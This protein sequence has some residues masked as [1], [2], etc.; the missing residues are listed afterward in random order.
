MKHFISFFLAPV[1]ALLVLVLV[2]AGGSVEAESYQTTCGGGVPG[3]VHSNGGG[4]VP[5]F[6]SAD[7]PESPVAD[8]VYVGPSSI[9]CDGILSGKVRIINS[10]VRGGTISGNVV[11][12]NSVIGGPQY[13]GGYTLSISGNARIVGSYVESGTVTGTAVI[14]N[15]VKISENAQVY[16]AAKL[17]GKGTQVTGN[18]V[19]FGNAVVRG[20]TWV[21]G[22]GKVNC[23]RWVGV[24]IRD[25]QRGKCGRNGNPVLSKLPIPDVESLSNP[26]E[27]ENTESNW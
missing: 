17:S 2:L 15:G 16:G 26:T 21:F 7:E 22:H 12:R 1:F 3:Q 20:G 9:V 8:S 27:P 4:W 13:Y 6:A 19:V 10:T 24:D 11:I 5:L 14:R 18:A 23:G 25:D